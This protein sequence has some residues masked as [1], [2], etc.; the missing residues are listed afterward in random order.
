MFTPPDRPLSGLDKWVVLYGF[1]DPTRD[2][3][4][5]VSEPEG[6]DKETD[7]KS[8]AQTAKMRLQKG[9]RKILFAAA[10]PPVIRKTQTPYV[11]NFQ[12]PAPPA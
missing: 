4:S 3:R 11:V 8:A 2:P 9:R 5:G 12:P 6:F 10:Y 1:F 7:A